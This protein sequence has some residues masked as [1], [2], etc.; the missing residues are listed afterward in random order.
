MPANRDPAKRISV[1]IPALDEAPAISAT[2][3]RAAGGRNTE[4]IVV[5]GGSRDTTTAAARE[6][7]ARVMSAAAGRSRQMNAG[8]AAAEGE[9][10]LFLH[11]DTRLPPGWDRAVRRSLA[12]PGVAGGAFRLGIHAQGVSL[13]LIEVA[14]NFRSQVLQLPYGDQ[15]LFVRRRLFHRLGGFAD[16]PI[17]EDFDLVHRL[18]RKG[19]IVTVNQAVLTSARRW[20]RL[21]VLRTWLINQAVVVAFYAGVPPVR[22]AAWYRAGRPVATVSRPAGDRR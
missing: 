15:G 8:A 5:D 12:A 13:R 7:G 14:A 9:L 10:L 2:I 4:I 11:A 1:V 16:I 22:L 20:L 21:G 19:R 3:R 18:R 6:A 17:M